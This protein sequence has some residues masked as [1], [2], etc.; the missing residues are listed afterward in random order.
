MNQSSNA[1]AKFN[2]RSN[3]DDEH[4]GFNFT[5]F[6]TTARISLRKWPQLL[7]DL[8]RAPLKTTNN[9]PISG[10]WQVPIAYAFT[11]SIGVGLVSGAFAMPLGFL[12]GAT[13]VISGAIASFI[14]IFIFGALTNAL[15]MLMSKDP[16]LYRTILLASI[17]SI[18][19]VFSMIVSRFVP[20]LGLTGTFAYMYVLYFYCQSA[21]GFTKKQAQILIAGFLLLFTLPMMT[22]AILLYSL[23][24]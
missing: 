22:G 6:Q 16:G 17:L 19:S 15:L 9:L 8:F 13:S 10:D 2:T 20:I 4:S 5:D 23:Y 7:V 14:S 18:V 12:P 21:A 3:M 24:W 1:N 11:S